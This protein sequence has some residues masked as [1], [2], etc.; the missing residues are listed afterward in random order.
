MWKKGHTPWNKGKKK[1]TNTG[2]THFKKGMVPWNTGKK[3]PRTEARI[4]YDLRQKGVTKPKPKNF[5]ATMRK[6]NPPKG[7][8]VYRQKGKP[9]YVAIYKPEHPNARKKPPD[10]GY[11]LEHW[12]VMSNHIG[13]P[14]KTPEC[15]HHLDGN[16]QNNLIENLVLCKDAKEHNAIHTTMEEFMEE[17]FKLGEIEYDR[18]TKR[19]HRRCYC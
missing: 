16:K 19:F 17:L 15:I 18:K 5:S 3:M 7:R 11:V 14:L 9:T 1:A 4:A 12:Y 6:V 2:R 10:Y 8:K 13:R